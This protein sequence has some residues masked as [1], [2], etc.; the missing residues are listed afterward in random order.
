MNIEL[1]FLEQEIISDI[2]E[3]KI[4]MSQIRLLCPR[5]GFSEEDEQLFLNYS[6]PIIYSIWEGFVETSF[7]TY[8]R[9]LNKL[10]LDVNN[11][12]KQIL[13]YH[14]ESTFKQFKEYPEKIDNKIKFFGQLNSFYQSQKFEIYTPINTES[15]VGWKVLNRILTNFNLEKIP[16]YTEPKYHLAEELDKFLLDIRNRVAHGQNSVVVNR[17]GLERAIK[18]VE[19]LMDLVC[20]RIVTGYAAK[21]YLHIS[22]E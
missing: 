1:T 18:L 3:R 10:E 8:I 20:D 12:C 21:T 22:R 6:I 17:E 16:A 11:V 4:L 14:I 2:E 5:Y 19:L 13:V 15:N 9:E 7:Q